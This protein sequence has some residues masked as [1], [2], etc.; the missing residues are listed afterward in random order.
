[1][2]ESDD[3]RRGLESW[4]TTN[5][6]ATIAELE[7][8]ETSVG[9]SLPVEIRHLLRLSN[10]GSTFFGSPGTAADHYIDLWSTSELVPNNLEYQV[11]DYVPGFFAFGSNG[12]GELY[13][14]EKRL[15]SNGVFQLPAI[16]M[17]NSSLVEF[18]SSF[19]GF[20]ALFGQRCG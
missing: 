16:G 17:S 8:V 19:A 13:V 20:L 6:P 9:F 18:S 11:S 1:M 5:P 4:L 10:G 7:A 14:F 3:A 12:G 2:A 15:E